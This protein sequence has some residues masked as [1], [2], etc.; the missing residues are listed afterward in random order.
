MTVT[1]MVRA[2]TFIAPLRIALSA[3][4]LLIALLLMT[5]P[6]F[7]QSFRF[8]AIG[9]EGNQRIE[10]S[11]ILSFADIPRGQTVTAGQLNAGSQRVLASGLFEE[12]EI[13]PSGSRLIIR[14]TEF[15]T[16][17]RI[18]FEGNRRLND[19]ELA[20]VVQSQSRR[21]FSPSRAEQDAAAITAA[22]ET[23]G[24]LS[25][26][27]APQIIRR[28]D[29][30][31]DL[32]FE[33]FEGGVTE[34]ERLSFVGNR[35]FSDRRLRRVLETKQAGLLRTLVQRDTF[36]ADRIEF[37]KQILEDFYQSRGYVDFRTTAVN[38]EVTR[39]RDGV[40]VTF[41]VIEGQQFRFGA[42]T[43]TSEISE[44]DPDIFQ[45][46]LRIR[47]GRVYSPVV[48]ENS[49]SRL[50]RLALRQGLNFVRVEPRITR[51]DRDLTL[52]VEFALTRGPRVF[53]E[54]I[55][56]EGNT[57]TLD[58]VVRRQ[59]RVVEG[60]PFNPREIR[61]S[62]ERIRALGYFANSSVN[63]REGSAPDRVVIDVDVVEQPTGTL[64]FGANYNTASGLGL[65]ASFS[66]RNFLGRGQRLNLALNTS[67]SNALF[68]FGFTEPSL[69]ARDLAFGLNMSYRQTDNDNALY[70]T[71]TAVFSPSFTFPISENGR[72]Q[73]RYAAEYT[74]ITDVSTDSALI[75][76]EA[77]QGAQLASLFGY[78]YSWDNRRS[79]LDPTSGIVF[80]FSQDYAG[81]GG[82]AEYL[83]TTAL[84]GAE[85]RVLN[86][87]VTLRATLEGGTLAFSG[88]P[89]RVT[90]RFFMGPRVMRGF[91]PGGIG[92]RDAVT[93]DA[94]GG[95]MFAVARLEA[96]FPLGLPE[97]Y[98]IT[99]GLFYDVGS[100]W[101]LDE[102]T[103]AIYTDFSARSVIGFS[104]FWTTPI[105]PLRFN[106]TRAVEKE[107]FD[108]EQTFDLT[109]STQF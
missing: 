92:P 34:I 75:R 46:A 90:D 108:R 104:L 58:Q 70:D 67:A 14:V 100:L 42:V 88:N 45:R 80:R 61:E 44:A 64:S 59:F 63:A 6:A 28:S 23:Q 40:F 71:T 51:N 32:V 83:K 66:E 4:I 7:A 82:D 97:E 39:E 107:Q 15:P 30:R 72:L 54:R 43:T 13:I 57:T 47:S 81:L 60:D 77:D 87:D 103:D 8:N 99:G 33:I 20:T 55:D 19:D 76:L 16:I 48:V 98:G 11:T 41:N 74:D 68:S 52:D 10:T 38:S 89:S 78:S 96:D 62:A 85:T 29:N 36:V 50:E 109:I 56:I 102:A 35:V 106:W 69:L 86:E 94:L 5:Q 17:N 9:V 73:L 1:A 93:D 105:G 49:I 22:Y 91:E 101:D 24:R 31:V 84:I 3:L 53:V 79:G 95:N 2:K 18:S 37:D 65:V 25:A 21:V 12:V 27:V 26:S